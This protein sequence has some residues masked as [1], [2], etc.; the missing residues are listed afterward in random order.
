MDK[1]IDFTALDT[2]DMEVLAVSDNWQNRQLAA[3]SRRLPHGCVAGLVADTHAMV[4]EA[5]ADHP[6]LTAEQIRTLAFNINYTVRKQ[7]ARRSDTPDS[8][9]DIL[10]ADPMDRVSLAAHGQLH[11]REMRRNERWGA[12]VDAMAVA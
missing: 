6:D 5:I 12:I 4:L 7:I 1:L 9:L 3:K 2:A 8:I 11:A 10:T